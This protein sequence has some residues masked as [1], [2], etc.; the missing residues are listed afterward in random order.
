MVTN[1]RNM[2]RVFDVELSAALGILVRAVAP[3]TGSVYTYHP[4]PALDMWVSQQEL[5]E[6][7]KR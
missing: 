6:R 3:K 2:I 4:V 1:E 7:N 5:N